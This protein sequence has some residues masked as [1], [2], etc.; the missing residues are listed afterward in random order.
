M[1]FLERPDIPRSMF[2]IPGLNPW[3]ILFCFVLLGW[4]FNKGK[5][6][7]RWD[8]PAH[9]NWLLIIY[10][11]VIIISLARLIYDR[12]EFN[13]YYELMGLSAPSNSQLII[14]H[15][16]NSTKYVLPAIM[17]FHGMNT[18]NRFKWAIA[19]IFLLVFFL[20]I[21][22]IKWMPLSE[23]SSGLDLKTRSIRILDR[24][25]GYH[26]VDL[27]ALLAGGAWAY[28]V[29]RIYFSSIFKSNFLLIIS[30]T[31]I[32][33]MVLTGGRMGFLAWIGIA[34]VLAWFRWKRFL[35][36]VPILL[37]LLML[38]TPFFFDRLSQGISSDNEAHDYR[39]E[40]V[41]QE[42]EFSEDFD[43]YTITAGRI[44]AWSLVV[45]KIMEAPILG[46][47]LLAMKNSGIARYMIE[48]YQ[49]ATFPHPHNA[50]LQLILDNG[51]ILAIPILLFFWIIV[52]YSLQLFRDSS[53]PMYTVAGGVALS[54][55][56]AQLFA[57]LGSQSFYPKESSLAMWCA[58]AIMLRVYVLRKQLINSRKRLSNDT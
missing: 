23:V 6:G 24:E 55:V 12:S 35:I 45:D 2:D 41:Q 5:E 53:N 15:L 28:Y 51:I 3:N 7:L 29:A 49:N 19:A 57:S 21:Q 43:L 22:V 47:G 50:Y 11:T 20:A 33:A 16:L 42:F 58:L 4:L 39:S 25:I 13:L 8:M 54:F 40:I 34:V 31:T 56:L 52:K 48:Q 36:I 37:G 10:L 46:Y 44:V 27:S 17:I 26:R 38:V 32:L 30:V 18:E 9:I 1:A 14:D